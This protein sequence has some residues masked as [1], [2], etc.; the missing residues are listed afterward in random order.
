M[1]TSL[2]N[3]LAKVFLAV[4]LAAASPIAIAAT[5]DSATNAPSEADKAWKELEKALQ[6]EMPPAEWQGHPTDEQRAAFRAHQAERAA[7]AAEKAKDF[8][9][10]YPSYPKA[11]EA[12]KREGDM[13]QVAVQLGNTN[14]VAEFRKLQE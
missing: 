8:Y 9:T 10:R 2:P 7:A 11:A 6:P 3:S 4:A 5:S 14:K 12:K 13:L 1:K